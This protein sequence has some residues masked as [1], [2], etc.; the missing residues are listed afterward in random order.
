VFSAPE[1]V[2]RRTTASAECSALATCDRG[3]CEKI[4]FVTSTMTAGALGGLA[5][6]DALCQALASAAGKKGRYLA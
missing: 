3:A 4:V 5:G 1:T 2:L 6:A